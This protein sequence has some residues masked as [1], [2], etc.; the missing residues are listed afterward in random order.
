MRWTYIR[1][2]CVGVDVR[3]NVCVRASARVH[4]HACGRTYVHAYGRTYV[5][6]YVCAYVYVC[7]C[8]AASMLAFACCIWHFC[9][10]CKQSGA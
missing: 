10:S 7:V 5:Y 8:A 9:Y 1:S 4:V 6:A 3:G 2:W